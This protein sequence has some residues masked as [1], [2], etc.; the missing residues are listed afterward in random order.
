[1]PLASTAPRE[2]L[3]NVS[4]AEWSPDGSE[5]AVV[6]R[7]GAL[8]RLEYPPGKV[9][10]ESAGYLSDV[11]ISPRGDRIAYM[12]HFKP[13]DNRGRVLIIDLEGMVLARSPESWGEEGLVWSAGGDRVLFTAAY[14]NNALALWSMSEDG[15]IRQLA[16]APESLVVLDRSPDGR[17]LTATDSSRLALV[18]RLA[19]EPEERVAS[20]LGSSYAS[21]LTRDG[22]ALLFCDQSSFSGI[23]Y[24]AYLLRAGG[25][26]P[27]R[28]GEG[29]PNDLSPD[30][31]LVLAT[32]SSEPARLV[33]YPTGAGATRDIS[34]E[35][36]TSYQTGFFLGGSRSVLTCGTFE[37]RTGR[38]FV[39]SLDDGSTRAVSVEG[40]AEG[41]PDPSGRQV[42][43]RRDDGSWVRFSI[44][45][46]AQE[47][48][49]ALT[50]A[51]AVMS[52]GEA[53]R[54]AQVLQPFTVPT[55]IENVD[56][57][58]GERTL[59]QT[60]GPDDTTGVTEIW[61]AARSEDGSAYVYN[62]ERTLGHL[63]A[64]EGVR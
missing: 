63:F 20:G 47:P 5:L 57:A 2:V 58:T 25:G 42:L 13:V 37:N 29:W 53:A 31:S 15:S 64:I 59:V 55:R 32:V 52:V 60:L 45:D 27:L 38:C 11:R 14:E 17:L 19:G 7:V 8:S 35:G 1:M 46:G 39:R 54:S 43:A 44:D 4:A 34:I 36:F 62:Y 3:E 41:Y 23:N 30:G 26:P 24:A 22:S 50:A 33:L 49:P 6:H 40:T 16:S 10:A 61:F 56:L 48:V 9:L 21:R 28:L 51:D 18:A 12:E